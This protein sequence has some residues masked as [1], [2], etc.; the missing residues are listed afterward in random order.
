MATIKWQEAYSVGVKELD[1]QH[2]DLLDIFNTVFI[3]SIIANSLRLHAL[4]NGRTISQT[5][6]FP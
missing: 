3:I 2:K 4:C 1:D 6:K 5:S